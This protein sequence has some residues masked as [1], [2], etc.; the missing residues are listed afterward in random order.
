MTMH[1]WFS[2]LQTSPALI[3]GWILISFLAACSMPAQADSAPEWLRTAAQ[4][5]VP[6]FPNETKVVILLD[7]QITTVK[8]NGEIETLYRR[9]FRILRPDTAVDFSRGVSVG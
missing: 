1:K 2:K 6:D 7:E 5:K 8:D 3:A 9:A 4:Q